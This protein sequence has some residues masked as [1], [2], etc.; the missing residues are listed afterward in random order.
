MARVGV[1]RFLARTPL[2]PQW[3]LGQRRIPRGLE[4]ASG[5]LLDI[6]AA[7]RWIA[8][9]LPAHVRYVA[10]DYPATGR[11]LYG[12]RPDIFADGARLPVADGAVDNVTCLEVLEHVPDPALVVS[13]V[14][15]VLRPGGSAWLS[16]P[17]L[18]PVHDAPFDFQRYTAHG[19]RRDCERAGLVIAALRRTG[20]PVRTAGLLASLAIAGPFRDRGGAWYL[21]LPVALALVVLVNCGAFA[22][23]LVWPDWDAMSSGYEVELRKP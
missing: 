1:L 18:Y 19:L 21:L 5:V 20:H 7:D 23:S 8:A 17:F 2:H 10:L 11:D 4:N 16:M 6:G 12:A 9:R 14:A 22:L 3:L 13:E 15:R